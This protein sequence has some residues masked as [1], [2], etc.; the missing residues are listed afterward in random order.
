[1]AIDL[2]TGKRSRTEIARIPH[3]V[4]VVIG[5]GQQRMNPNMV[6]PVGFIVEAA[7][8]GQTKKRWEFDAFEELRHN[9]FLR[10]RHSPPS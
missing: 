3:T 1:M 9:R 4:A 6:D 5:I 7:Q 10:R 8:A 2:G